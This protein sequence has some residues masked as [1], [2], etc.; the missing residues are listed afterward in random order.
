MKIPFDTTVHPVEKKRGKKIDGR[1]FVCFIVAV[2]GAVGCFID[3]RRRG[4]D[5]NRL[6]RHIRRDI[7]RYEKKR[8]QN[9]TETFPNGR[10]KKRTAAACF[11]FTTHVVLLVAVCESSR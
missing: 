2:I 5:D 1:L 8:V 11:S 7:E 4:I 6:P 9:V 3:R 10:E